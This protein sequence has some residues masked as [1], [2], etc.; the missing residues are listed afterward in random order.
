MH[1]GPFKG[2]RFFLFVSLT[3]EHLGKACC[4]LVVRACHQQRFLSVRMVVASL[5][6]METLSKI[7]VL[8]ISTK[9]I[10]MLHKDNA[11]YCCCALP[12]LGLDCC[13]CEE[14]SFVK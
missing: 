13:F 10:A 2:R 1:A 4:W 6:V 14:P 8:I 9:G 3:V 12:V 5:A 7:V 11:K